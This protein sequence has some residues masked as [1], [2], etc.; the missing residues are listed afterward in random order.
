[1]PPSAVREKCMVNENEVVML[2]LGIGVSFLMFSYRRHLRQIP[3]WSTFR[4][5]YI[6]LMVAFV[7]TIAEGFLWGRTLNFIEHF[8][9][10]ISA[11]LTA[12]WT[13]N[14][15]TERTQGESRAG[16]HS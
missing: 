6:V 5:A 11:V 1:M 15:T 9:Y 12:V 10:A 14:F 7:M 4:W 2:A 3:R 13:W 16:Q 8:C